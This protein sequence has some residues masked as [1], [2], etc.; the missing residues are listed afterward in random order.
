MQMQMMSCCWLLLAMLACHLLFMCWL[1]YADVFLLFM[2]RYS[3]C[4]CPCRAELFLPVQSGAVASAWAPLISDLRYVCISLCFGS[5]LSSFRPHNQLESPFG[6]RAPEIARLYCINSSTHALLHL[7]RETTTW[8]CAFVI[9]DQDLLRQLGGVVLPG[10]STL[11]RRGI[12][13]GR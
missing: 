5:N 13:P 8:A 6:T 2:P 3:R 4:F 10:A 12:R 11:R 1:A 9:A 7:T